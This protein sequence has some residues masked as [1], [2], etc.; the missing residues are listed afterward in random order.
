MTRRPSMRL[1]LS[2]EAAVMA[3]MTRLR[4]ARQLTPA[5]SFAL[6]V[7]AGLATGMVAVLTWM[8]GG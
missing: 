6:A 8:L 2:V 3:W 1:A 4:P 7:G 5:E